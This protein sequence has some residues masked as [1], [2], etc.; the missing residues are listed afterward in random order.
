MKKL[1]PTLVLLAAASAANAQVVFSQPFDFTAG[2]NGAVTQ[3]GNP[4]VI[5]WAGAH[6]TAGTALPWHSSNSGD[7]TSGTFL[8]SI[9]DGNFLYAIDTTGSTNPQAYMF[10]TT[11]LDVQIGSFNTTGYSTID[12]FTDTPGEALTGKTYG[13]LNSLDVTI[14]I[15]D[16][17]NIPVH[18]ALEVNLGSGPEWVITE[19]GFN[20]VDNTNSLYQVTTDN[21]V[22]WLQ[23]V[24]T[25]GSFLV[26][27]PSGAGILIP[28]TAEITGYG[29]YSDIPDASV[30]GDTR[31]RMFNYNIDA[32]PE[33]STYALLLGAAALLL[34]VRRRQS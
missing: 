12:F 7:G 32:V 11:D 8:F 17:T 19:L 21:S 33:P 25:P 30:G 2:K 13:D 3:E 18:F 23:N 22:A 27:G 10:H 34:V 29:L 15:P 5:G 16:A 24:Y 26:N 9:S 4:Y 31:V 28:D 14:R 6:T 1:I 20:G